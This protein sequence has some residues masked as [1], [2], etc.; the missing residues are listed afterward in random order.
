MNGDFSPYSISQFTGIN[1]QLHDEPLRN[2]LFTFGSMDGF[3]DRLEGKKAGSSHFSPKTVIIPVDSEARQLA[4][5]EDGRNAIVAR[6]FTDWTSIYCVSPF[7]PAQAWR[8]LA[9]ISGTHRYIDTED[10]VYANR[11]MVSVVARNSGKRTIHLPAKKLN[12]LG[13]SRKNIQ[14]LV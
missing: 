2:T 11:S 6:R 7:L 4:C 12:L 9:A 8:N 14:S 3:C 1:V 13:T 5:F 10:V